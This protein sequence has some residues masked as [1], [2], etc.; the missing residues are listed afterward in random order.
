MNP[1]TVLGNGVRKL[2][3]SG[4]FG[5]LMILAFFLGSVFQYNLSAQCQLSCRGKVNISVGVGCEA[6]ITPLLLLTS[7]I[8][9]PS[10][11]YRVDVLNPYTMKPIPSSPYV[12]FEHI[13]K[14]FKVMVYDSTSKNSC[15]STLLVEDKF[16]PVIECRN[17]T[18]YCNDSTKLDPPVFYDYCDTSATIDLLHHEAILLHCDPLFIKKLVR[19]WRAKDA[20]G[21]Q[22]LLC[23]DTIWLKRVPIDSVKFPKDFTKATNCALECWGPW[24]KDAQGHPHPDT[25]GVPYYAGNP[26]WPD[27]S[28][29]CNLGTSY[30]DIVLVKNECKTKILRM[31]RVVEWWCGTAVVKSHAQTIEISDMTPPTL[32]CPYDITISVSSGYECFANFKLPPAI[33]DDHCQDS[34]IV[35]IHYQ[36]GVL[37][38]SNGG[39]IKLPIG[40]HRIVYKARDICYN[41]DSCAMFI[42][43][44]DKTPPIAICDR[45]TV[46]SM[47]RDDEVHVYADVLD[48]GSYDGCHIDSLLVRRMDNG[49]ACGF[50]DNIF[51]PYVRFCCQD[52]GK[53]IQVVFRVVDKSGNTNDCMVMVQVQDKTPPV[54][55][56]P[57]DVTID[58]NK[59]VDTTNFKRFG[60]AS[61]YDNCVVTI[62]EQVVPHL[63]QCNIGY[64]A[65]NFIVTDNMGR[66]D[67]CTQ[68]IWVRNP[69]PFD[70]NDIIW[71][72]DTTINGC[73]ANVSPQNLPDTFGFPIIIDRT[74]A[75]AG[76][77]FEDS[78]FS[79]IQGSEVCQKILRKWKVIDWCQQYTDTSGNIIIPNWTH[80][81]VI[82]VLNKNPP[83]ITD[84]CDTVMICLTGANC[85]KERVRLSHEAFDD[86]TPDDLLRSGFK[87]DLYNNG[88]YDSS[89][90]IN[91]NRITF[92]A[93]LPLGE[94]KFFWIFEDQC[95]NETVCQQIVRVINC[96]APTA[97]C[98]SGVAINLMGIDSDQ[99]GKIDTALIQIWASDLDHGSYQICGNPV[100]L[101]FS[102]DS[103]D[104]YRIYNCDSLGMRRVEIWVTDK[105]TGLQDRCITT[106]V[107]QDNNHHCNGSGGNLTGNIAGLLLTPDD[108]EIGEVKIIVEEFGNSIYESEANGKF[109][110][111]DLHIG[112]DYTIKALKDNNYLDG[113]TTFD[114]VQIQKHILGNLDLN[115]PWRMLAA[116]INADNNITAS[117][118]SALRKLILG[119]DYKYRNNLSWKFVE[120]T[121][122]FPDPNN[123]WLEPLP[124]EYQI[125]SLPGDMMFLDFKGIKIGDVSKSIWGEFNSPKVETR[126]ARKIDLYPAKSIGNKIPVFAKDVASID[127]IQ[128]TLQLNSD[129][130][131]LNGIQ[132][133]LIP[134]SDQNIG[135]SWLGQGILLV[136]WSSAES[137]QI[138]GEEALFYIE[139]S[140]ELSEEELPQLSINSSILKAE[141]YSNGS[142]IMSIAWNNENNAS[143]N[144]IIFGTLIPNPFVQQTELNINLSQAGAINYAIHDLEGREIF[145]TI[146]YGQK[147]NNLITIKRSQLPTSGVYT[148]KVDA[149]GLSKT[150]KLIVIN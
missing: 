13:K 56:C 135:W 29:Y 26:L 117:D 43:V 114:I 119:V 132:P 55:Y 108:K 93:E 52:V 138:N 125:Q 48:D 68:R 35:D 44:V 66:T 113:I 16:G 100:T 120:S 57:H 91:G 116:D 70:E 51:K 85:I 14:E 141:I 60:T 96:K 148:L 109:A 111:Q 88:L 124:E 105:L 149:S 81:Q 37:L 49:A 63:N 102:K 34:V 123:P 47:T 142:E 140:K 84:D 80:E 42:T 72:Y 103:S 122:T 12:H 36:H 94:H 87:L 83:K 27:F 76:I 145:T 61:Y 19:E 146:E 131:K 24:P 23:V 15:W 33:V 92:D 40:V 79:Y 28:A 144:E 75:L 101:S 118:I 2:C 86:C 45:E 129:L 104:K 71:P 10:A 112:R 134:V 39:F 18:I 106:V 6:E 126:S 82:K 31:W 127:G 150:Y 41:E 32:H 107:V 130:V 115:S 97:Y 78:K 30:E 98:L 54:V 50:N 38:N 59:H 73:G 25:T 69:D 4:P 21:N 147:G 62:V 20:W 89:Y 74:C 136:S 90:H 17:D 110:F 137:L 65:R 3:P 121:Y 11:R 1:K 139:L 64:F 143:Q 128:F 95:G 133:G 53:S 58:C 7:G 22:S 46:V 99:N 8:N 67:T 77:S 5:Y 9:C